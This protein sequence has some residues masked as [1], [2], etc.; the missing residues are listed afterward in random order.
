MVT[1]NY[2]VVLTICRLLEAIG[3]SEEVSFLDY[4]VDNED[5]VRSLAREFIKPS[6]ELVTREKREYI[7]DSL[8]FYATIGEAPFTQLKARCQELSM[9]DPSDWHL[10]LTWVGREMFGEGFPPH[11]DA[12][13]YVE[14]LD[15]RRAETVF[16]VVEYPD[17]PWR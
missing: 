5:E 7:Y 11:R 2:Y 13:E 16:H 4:D 17:S 6:L 14:V 15:E 1:V 8:A 3:L 10:F 12:N 9:I